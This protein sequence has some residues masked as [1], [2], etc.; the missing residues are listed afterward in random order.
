MDQPLI[1]KFSFPKK[2]RLRIYYRMRKVNRRWQKLR[3]FIQFSW[4]W[5]RWRFSVVEILKSFFCIHIYYADIFE[6]VLWFVVAFVRYAVLWC[7]VSKQMVHRI[8]I[9]SETIDDSKIDSI[10][11]RYNLRLTFHKMMSQKES[12][13]HTLERRI[14]IFRLTPVSM[15]VCVQHILRAIVATP[16]VADPVVLLLHVIK[17]HNTRA[18]CTI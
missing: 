12:S 15:C 4:P 8:A 18:Y 9:Y 2:R 7:V 6:F 14:A 16:R 5:N 1:K 11:S 17:N 10:M 3:I 13:T